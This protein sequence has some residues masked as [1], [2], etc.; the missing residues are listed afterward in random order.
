VRKTKKKV[1]KT[2]KIKN[3]QMSLLCHRKRLVEKFQNSRIHNFNFMN[4]C[5]EL[6]YFNFTISSLRINNFIFIYSWIAKF[7]TLINEVKFL[8]FKCPQLSFV[9]MSRRVILYSL[10]LCEM[11]LNWWT[12]LIQITLTL[13]QNFFNLEII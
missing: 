1:S 7:K 4:S 2:K 10:M 12:R 8:I 5:F 6:H 13:C 11:K 3:L 9:V